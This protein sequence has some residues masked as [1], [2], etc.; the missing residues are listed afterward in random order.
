MLLLTLNAYF[1]CG[2]GGRA[3]PAARQSF[4]FI[5][6]APVLVF[7]DPVGRSISA[8]PHS[9]APAGILPCKTTLKVT[10]GY[11]GFI[12]IAGN[13]VCLSSVEGLTDGMPLGQVKYR[14]QHSGQDWIRGA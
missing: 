2:H 4:V 1:L 13:P 12:R 5:D 14:V 6:G 11:S 7:G 10:Q 3:N 8:C 9:I